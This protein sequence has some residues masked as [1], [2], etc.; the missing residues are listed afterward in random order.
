VMVWYGI[1]GH[2]D[3]TLFRRS[4][5]LLALDLNNTTRGK[6]KTVCWSLVNKT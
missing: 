6:E 2:V 5:R 4:M 1:D 3:L